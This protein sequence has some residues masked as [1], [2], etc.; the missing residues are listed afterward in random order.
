MRE[1]CEHRTWRHTC[2]E[3]ENRASPPNWLLVMPCVDAG[4][5]FVGFRATGWNTNRMFDCIGQILGRHR[6]RTT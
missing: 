1:G 6:A 4:F 3:T 2:R 5:K